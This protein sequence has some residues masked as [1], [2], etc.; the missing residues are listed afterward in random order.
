MNSYAD[1]II[2][3]IYHEGDIDIVFFGQLLA[4]VSFRCDIDDDLVASPKL[5]DRRVYD[6]LSLAAYLISN[7]DFRAQRG[8][9]NTDDTFCYLPFD[10]G[11]D[12]FSDFIRKQ[13]LDGGIDGID[14]QYTTSLVKILPGR[15]VSA[16]PDEIAALF[17]GPEWK[18][19]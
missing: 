5:P 6:A 18:S 14:L 8:H 4:Y 3:E 11:F 9:R 15:K 12:E 16:V 17:I 10:Y 1:D 19:S 2:G 7:G 13:Y